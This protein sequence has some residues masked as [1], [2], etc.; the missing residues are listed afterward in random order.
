M[1]LYALYEIK[2]SCLIGDTGIQV[3]WPIKPIRNLRQIHFEW[4][5]SANCAESFNIVFE[6]KNFLQ[7]VLAMDSFIFFTAGYLID[8]KTC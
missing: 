6:S 2:E 1:T 3:C 4:T 8:E 5:S 7:F